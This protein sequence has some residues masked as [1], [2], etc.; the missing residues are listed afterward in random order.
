MK[1]NK[2][3]MLNING[4]KIR[5]LFQIILPFFHKDKKQ[6]MK[7]IFLYLMPLK[8]RHELTKVK[9]ANRPEQC[10]E[11]SKAKSRIFLNES[12][13]LTKKSRI[14]LGANLSSHELSRHPF[15]IYLINNKYTFKIE[16]Y[17]IC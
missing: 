7:M 15:C 14:V 5:I 1:E 12:R 2:D 9:V 6:G 4:A 17:T 11:L 10:R 8:K 3:S 16:D 13:E